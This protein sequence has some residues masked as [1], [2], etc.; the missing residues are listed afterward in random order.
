VGERA[1]AF[2]LVSDAA[3]KGAVKMFTHALSRVHLSNDRMASFLAT[4]GSCEALKIAQDLDSK[5]EALQAEQPVER[6]FEIR[7][8]RR[9]LDLQRNT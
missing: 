7:L 8:Y 6:S 9:H 1:V 4:Y 2:G 3:T 5:L